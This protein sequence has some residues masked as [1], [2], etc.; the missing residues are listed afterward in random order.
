MSLAEKS[1]GKLLFL[2]G[3]A[4]LFRA[5]GPEL[6]GTAAL[7]TNLLAAVVIQ[8][9]LLLSPGRLVAWVLLVGLG[10]DGL[11][12][13]ALGHHSLVMGLTALLVRTQ[14][15]WWLGA[16]AGEQAAGS[17]LASVSFFALDRFFHL[18]ETRSWDW[19]FVLS[20]NLVIAG[21]VNGLVSVAIG[22]WLE[23]RA[24]PTSSRVSRR[25]W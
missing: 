16:S 25:S 7:T 11:T 2:A 14:K 15:G 1:F 8:A 22:W 6:Y 20:V 13:S 5:I 18:V 23:W 3:G 24:N 17:V 4:W 10:W 9:G 19:P 12:F 21:L